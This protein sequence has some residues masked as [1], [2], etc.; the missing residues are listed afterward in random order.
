[1]IRQFST[2]LKNFYL[3]CELEHDDGDGVVVIMCVNVRC[4]ARGCDRLMDG[5]KD[6]RVDRAQYVDTEDY[7][8]QDQRILNLVEGLLDC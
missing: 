6:R 7:Y 1:V 2:F 4:D 3:F 5:S 8:S